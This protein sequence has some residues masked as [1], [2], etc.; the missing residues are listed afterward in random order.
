MPKIQYFQPPGP[1]LPPAT[2]RKNLRT[3]VLPISVLAGLLL[4]VLAVGALVLGLVNASYFTAHGA[5]RIDCTSGK[6]LDGGGAHVGAT[7]RL[8]DVRDG[9]LA[10]SAPLVRE[11]GASRGGTCLASFTITDVY[12]SDAFL[13]EIGDADPQRVTRAE[14]GEGIVLY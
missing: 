11:S 13:V 4:L 8:I 1:P 6:A 9:D 12:E 14:L 2:W 5:V 10:G 7:V 3:W